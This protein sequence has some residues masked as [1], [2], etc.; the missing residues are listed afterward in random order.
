MPRRFLGPLAGVL[1]AL[2]LPFLRRHTQTALRNL[3]RAYPESSA[4]EKERILRDSAK[5]LILAGLEIF[6]VHAGQ[7]PLRYLDSVS[8]LEKVEE[9]KAKGRGI[10]HVTAH[11]GNWELLVLIYARLGY[12]PRAL[13]QNLKDPRFDRLLDDFHESHGVGLIRRG[14]SALG[15]FR[16]LARGGVLGI[17]ADM[18]TNVDSVEAPF[19][20]RRVRAPLG[21][22]VLARRSGAALIPAFL[23][24]NERGG[25]DLSVGEKIELDGLSDAEGAAAYTQAIEA[26]IRR[27]PGQWAWFQ[28]R[29]QEPGDGEKPQGEN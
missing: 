18:D 13:R 22:V 17:L 4:A 12:A 14:G 15:A 28:R 24:R 26:A 9:A 23:S 29:F 19:F 20:G 21:P 5:S 3:A 25:H 6:G 10:V 11:L 7:D 27:D 2:L 1:T 8:G 16:V